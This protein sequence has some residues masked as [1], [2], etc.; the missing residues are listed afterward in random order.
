MLKVA[1]PSERRER[2]V[3]HLLSDPHASFIDLGPG[4]YESRI[5]KHRRARDLAIQLQALSPT[6]TSSS[7]KAKPL[8]PTPPPDPK[9]T[10]QYPAPPGAFGLPIHPPI[11][12]SDAA[13][14]DLVPASGAVVPSKA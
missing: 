4:Y 6:N 11:F 3:Y 7:A 12:G 2:L 8:S 5:N 9:P 13:E 1:R 14:A 10:K